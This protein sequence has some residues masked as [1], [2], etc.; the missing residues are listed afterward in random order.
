VRADPFAQLRLLDVQVLDTLLDQLAHR[1]ATLPEL[2]ELEE[3]AIARRDLSAQR[4]EAETSVD[5]LTR[6]QRKADADVEAVKSRRARN[7]ERL[8]RG[9]VSNPRE[10]EGLQHEISSLDRRIAVLEDE[11]LEVMEQLESAQRQLQ[12]VRASLSDVESRTD[13]AVAARDDS[14]QRIDAEAEKAR[15]ERDLLAADIPENLLT[16]YQQ[17]RAQKGGVGAAALEGRRCTGCQLELNPSER[18]EIAHAPSDE[19]VRCEDCR[20]ILVRVPASGV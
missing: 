8:D 6:Q 2:R 13:S 11:E 16:L 10:L 1:R 3:L 19:V 4:V 7:Q 15:S 5:D 20:R 14:I 17:L 9:Q 18:A 12:E